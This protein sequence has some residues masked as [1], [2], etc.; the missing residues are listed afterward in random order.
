MG[1]VTE[2]NMVRIGHLELFRIQGSQK[3]NEEKYGNQEMGSQ[4]MDGRKHYNEKFASVQW[5]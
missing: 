4:L 3:M 2:I 1:T 5:T